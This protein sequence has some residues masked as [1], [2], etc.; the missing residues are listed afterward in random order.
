MLTMPASR[1][2]ILAL[3]VLLALGAC[4]RRADPLL[5]PQPE[6]LAAPGPDSFLVRLETSRGPVAVM[7]HRAWAPL[8]ADRFHYL[9]RA[10]FY[11]GV[12]VYRV[13]P[14]YVAQFGYRGVPAIDSLWTA[15]PLDDEPVVASNT[16]GRVAFARSG[17]R[18]RDTHLF[19]NLRDNARLDTLGGLGFPPF[20]EVVGGMTA[21]DSLYGGYSRHPE[22]PPPSQDSI[23]RQGSAYL[24]RVYPLLDRIERA[25]VVREWR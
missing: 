24:E 3:G 11:D 18:T 23:Q 2:L 21:V 22:L 8:A 19:V 17:P 7:A 12:H 20:A 6:R 25:A 16:R 4:Q 5:A 1:S 15:L 14:G 10:G 13:A 9:V